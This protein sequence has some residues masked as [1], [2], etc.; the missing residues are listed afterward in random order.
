MTHEINPAS[1]TDHGRPEEL[2][3]LLT[4]E[5][6]ARTLRISRTM[7]YELVNRANFPAVRIGRAIRVPRDAL[8][9]WLEAQTGADQRSLD[10]VLSVKRSRLSVRK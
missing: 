6:L 4:V 9:R 2:P 3:L 8:L 7:A 10:Q 5:E 1:A